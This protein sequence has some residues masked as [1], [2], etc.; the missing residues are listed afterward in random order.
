MLVFATLDVVL[1][2]IEMLGDGAYKVVRTTSRDVY[3]KFAVRNEAL[4]LRHEQRLVML[5]QT[6]EI[7]ALAYLE[8]QVYT[9]AESYLRSF[10]PRTRRK[11]LETLIVYLWFKKPRVGQHATINGILRNAL[12]RISHMSARIRDDRPDIQ[13]LLK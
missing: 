7:S 13:A 12:L 4:R 8:G 10:R 11:L 2:L 9:L 5:I 3:Q 1:K 6:T